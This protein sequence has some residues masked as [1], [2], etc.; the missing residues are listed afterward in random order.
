M[1]EMRM[2]NRRIALKEK[3]EK[4]E[5]ETHFRWGLNAQVLGIVTFSRIFDFTAWSTQGTYY[6]VGIRYTVVIYTVACV[7]PKLNHKFN[8]SGIQVLQA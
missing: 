1:N 4:K 8:S 2:Q 5:T 3:R 6:T 7:L